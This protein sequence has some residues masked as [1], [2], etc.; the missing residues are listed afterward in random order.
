MTLASTVSSRAPFK[1]RWAA[2]MLAF[3]GVGL[4]AASPGAWANPDDAKLPETLRRGYVAPIDGPANDTAYAH[5]ALGLVRQGF[6]R[7]SLYVAWRVMQL[8]PGALAK[9]SHERLGSWTVGTFRPEPKVDEI[10]AWLALRA[11]VGAAPLASKPDYY[12][13]TTVMVGNERMTG[14]EGQC[15]ADAFSLATQ[16]LQSLK[17]EPS[18]RDA[19]RMAWVAGQDAVFARCTWSPGSTQP[20]PP[21]P[22]PLPAGSPAKLLAFNAYQRASALFYGEDYAA[23]L[24]A[25]DAIAEDKEH[26]IRPWAMLGAM[27]SLVRGTVRDNT[28]NLAFNEA[29]GKKGLRGKALTEALVPASDQRSAREAAMLAQMETRLKSALA[30]SSL[31]SA[32]S[33]MKYTMRRALWQ[34]RPGFPLGEAMKV[35]DKPEQNPYV[36]GHVDVVREL[37]DKVVPSQP[38]EAFQAELLKYRWYDFVSTV[39]AC[40]DQ[41]KA[42]DAARCERAHGHALARWQESQSNSW[43]LA[44]LMTARGTMAAALPVAQAARKVDTSRPEWASLQFYAARVLR[45]QGQSEEAAAALKAV[46]SSGKVHKRDLPLVEAALKA[47]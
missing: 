9:E 7:A 27:R 33:A 26:V 10:E 39:Q 12:R 35:M 30:D 43:M 46:L 47:S 2:W 44:A 36:M 41:P 31:A 11:T 28:W 40:S 34:L 8:P 14:T 3:A 23:A 29:Y 19:D 45:S 5:G 21:M 20:A 32:H 38:S 15:G 13:D 1:A 25:F 42:F 22:A 37:H 24:K 16:I 4:S 17:A 18:M 6:G